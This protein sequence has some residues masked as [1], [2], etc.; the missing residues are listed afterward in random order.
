MRRAA[1][2]GV[3]VQSHP[4]PLRPTELVNRVLREGLIPFPEVARQLGIH[5]STLH[6]WRSRRG[7]K[8]RLEAIRLVGRWM[9]SWQAVDRFVTSQSN[10]TQSAEP[11]VRT[12]G[13]R[14]ATIQRQLDEE[15]L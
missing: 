12:G 13:H 5:L 10:D 3:S 4:D 2:E 11:N 9:T 7:N 15:G 6:R 1:S 8:V 14:S